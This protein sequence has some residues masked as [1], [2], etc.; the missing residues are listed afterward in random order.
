MLLEIVPA[1]LMH[2]ILSFRVLSCVMETGCVVTGGKPNE[3]SFYTSNK[4][5]MICFIILLRLT[6]SHKAAEESVREDGILKM[7]M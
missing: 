3:E 7:K 5:Y 4:Y 6:E 2:Y 1:V